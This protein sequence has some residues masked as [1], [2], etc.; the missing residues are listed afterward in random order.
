[1]E[2]V[3]GAEAVAVNSSMRVSRSYSLRECA[4]GRFGA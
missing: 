2:L 4:A 3:S 1:M